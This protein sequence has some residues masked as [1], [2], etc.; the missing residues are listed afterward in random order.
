MMTWTVMMTSCEFTW[1][2]FLVYYFLPQY[3]ERVIISALEKNRG[4]S[5]GL[6]GPWWFSRS[7]RLSL[8]RYV[9]GCWR[10]FCMWL[11][12][13]SWQQILRN[14]SKNFYAASGWMQDVIIEFTCAHELAGNIF[15][16]IFFFLPSLFLRTN[17]GCFCLGQV[18][19]LCKIYV[20]RC[21]RNVFSFF[22]SLNEGS[23]V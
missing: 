20:L 21:R 6:A 15:G 3:C 23:K 17:Q 5:L 18:N 4:L 1:A 2:G 10:Y 9:C 8:R 19:Y 13:L 12:C 7:R 11:Y 14:V 16:F 22:R